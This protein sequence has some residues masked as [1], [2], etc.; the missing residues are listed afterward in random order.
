MRSISHLLVA[1]L[2]AAAIAVPAAGE[3]RSDD[4]IAPK[5]V[6]LMQQ[7]RSLLAAG[8][9]EDAQ[10]ALEASLAVDPRNRWAYVEAARVAEKQKLYGK[11]IR[12]TNKALA[13]EPN[14]LDA[15]AVQGEAMVEMG[16]VARARVN[17]QKIKT[18]CT[19]GCPQVAQLTDA[20]GR[21]P[22]VAAAS[23]PPEPK[24]D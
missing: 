17:L 16:A 8:K 20:I 5:S 10:T 4:E 15:L 13:M 22:R 6:E 3:R 12:L 2:A 23:V 21:G 1:G 24:K 18:I 19:K 14:D 11:A 7:G 9:F